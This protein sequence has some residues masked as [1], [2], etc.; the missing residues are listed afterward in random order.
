MPKI[1]QNG[2][3]L[4][5]MIILWLKYDIPKYTKIIE[6]NEFFPVFFKIFKIDKGPTQ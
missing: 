1:G 3:F 2:R 5:K 6:K 4:A